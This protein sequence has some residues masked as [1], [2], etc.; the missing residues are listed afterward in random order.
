MLYPIGIFVSIFLASLL[1]TKAGRNEADTILGIWMIVIGLHLFAYYS[2]ATGL[3]YEHTYLLGSTLPYPFLHGPFLYLYTFALTKPEALRTKVWLANFLLPAGVVLSTVPF[4][5]LPV[6]RKVYVFQNEGAGFETY[7]LIT[8]IL[9]N[10][11]GIAYIYLTHRLLQDHKRRISNIF[12]NQEKVNLGWLRF[13]FYGMG[14]I[15]IV[16][17]L[18]LGDALIFGM[19]TVFVVLIGYFGIKQA[20]IFSDQTLLLAG[21]EAGEELPLAIGVPD[22][23]SKKRK[24]AKSGLTQA[25]A[26]DLYVRLK[27]LMT[28]GKLYLEPELTLVQLAAHLDV[29]PNYLSQTINEIEG[30]SFYDYIN[31]L[32]IEEFKRRAV[33]AENQKFTLLAIAFDCGFNSKSAFNRV[34]KKATGLSPSEYVR[35]AATLP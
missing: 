29:H 1:L 6:D 10:I 8:T 22:V 19:A 27:I 17:I 33:L 9:L 34:F 28:S 20:G 14:L 5:L 26:S 15:W 13:L 7:L 11:S 2:L 24:Y 32:R 25:S 30:V 31:G 18:N 23:A 3:I 16:I 35:T 4:F 12:S 21:A